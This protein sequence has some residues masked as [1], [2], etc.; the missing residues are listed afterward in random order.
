MWDF[1]YLSSAFSVC[2]FDRA[3]VLS[4]WYLDFQILWYEFTDGIKFGLL[5]GAYTLSFICM[6]YNMCSAIVPS[7]IAD[8]F[9]FK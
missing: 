5:L 9:F 2:T 3:E 1:A 4:P 7:K 6:F 8:I